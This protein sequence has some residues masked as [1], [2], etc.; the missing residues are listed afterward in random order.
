MNRD[1]LDLIPDRYLFDQ[2]T[3]RLRRWLTDRGWHMSLAELIEE[4]ARRT[5]SRKE[6]RK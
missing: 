3:R 2:G 4:R 6:A 1:Q 5:T